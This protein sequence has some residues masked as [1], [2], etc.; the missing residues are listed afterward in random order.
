MNITLEEMS[1]KTILIGIT[2]Y[3]AEEEFIEQKQLWGRVIETSEKYIL[4]KLNNGEMFSLPPDLSSTKP[5]PAGEHRLR[6]TGEIVVNP[7]YLT[8]WNSY[9]NN[10]M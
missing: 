8:T 7:D 9:R 6:S 10:E 3:T 2:Y 1:G 4:V 5:A